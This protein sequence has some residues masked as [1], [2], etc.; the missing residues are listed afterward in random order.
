MPVG[1]QNSRARVKW[2]SRYLAL[3][4]EGPNSRLAKSR[5][6][7]WRL[8]LLNPNSM[9]S[10]NGCTYILRISADINIAPVTNHK[11]YFNLMIMQQKLSNNTLH[12]AAYDG[13][14]TNHHAVCQE[15]EMASSLFRFHRSYMSFLMKIRQSRWYQHYRYDRNT[16]SNS[17]DRLYRH[18]NCICTEK[19]RCT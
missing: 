16:K 4:R 8:H 17:I 5:D 3:S 1:S 7:L 6:T 2:F 12:K 14:H 11:P 9:L 18:L 15:T 10:D 13:L 19:I